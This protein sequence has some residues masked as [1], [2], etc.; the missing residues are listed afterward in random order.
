M[1]RLS[2]AVTLKRVTPRLTSML[3]VVR[4]SQPARSMASVT[5]TRDVTLPRSLRRHNG[6]KVKGTFTQQEMQRRVDMV[7]T[8]M[9]VHEIDTCVFTS[10]HNVNYFSDFLYCSFGRP[11]AFII[12]PEK[13]L[14]VS[15]GKRELILN[16]NKFC[17]DSEKT[18]VR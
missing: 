1:M 2:C 8:Y 17:V 16:S 5:S 11:Y 9:E 10:I 18:R 15:A 4:R 6:Q 14:T 13:T 3:R 12:T 7:R